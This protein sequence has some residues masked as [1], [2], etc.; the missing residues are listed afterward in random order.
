MPMTAS[1]LDPELRELLLPAKLVAARRLVE[2]LDVVE[3]GGADHVVRVQAAV[4]IL[5]RI[6]GPAN[7]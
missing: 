6:M 4:A 7:R 5:E 1:E 3:A 2:A